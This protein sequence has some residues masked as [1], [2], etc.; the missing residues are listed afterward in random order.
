MQPSPDVFLDIFSVKFDHRRGPVAG[1][2]LDVVVSTAG[3]EQL[4]RGILSQPVKAIAV[5]Q[6]A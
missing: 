1:D 6:S 3:L 4:N 5:V 2:C